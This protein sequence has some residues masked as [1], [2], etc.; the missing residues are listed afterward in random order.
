MIKPV[1]ECRGSC[2]VLRN[3]GISRPRSNRRRSLEGFA[4]R[5]RPPPRPR[6]PSSFFLDPLIIRTPCT[7]RRLTITAQRHALLLSLRVNSSRDFNQGKI[8]IFDLVRESE[9]KEGVSR[10]LDHNFRGKKGI[11]FARRIRKIQE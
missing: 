5:P 7:V 8:V 10:S 9:G 4:C 6:R 11:C 3:T 1:C 2:H